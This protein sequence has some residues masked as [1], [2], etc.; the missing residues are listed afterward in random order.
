MRIW[1]S[2]TAFDLPESVLALGTFDGLHAGHRVLIGRAMALA[3][4]MN[5]ACVVC[6]FDRHPLTLLSP[7]KAPK[8]LMTLNEKLSALEKMGV[9]GVLVETFD[10]ACAATEP[11]RYLRQLVTNMRARALVAG[12]NHHFGAHGRGDADMIRRM[13]D[14]LH[15]RA[16]ILPPVQDGADVISS[17]LIRD[18]LRHGDT[19]RAQRLMTE[20]VNSAAE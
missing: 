15:Y 12:F 6:T 13:A 18:L 19:D 4:A 2:Q 10:A 3:R 8:Q 17:T 14:E 11:E 5:C 16:E 7:K 1:R 9:D 20:K